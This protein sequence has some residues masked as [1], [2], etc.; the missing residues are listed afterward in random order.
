VVEGGDGNEA[1][2]GDGAIINSDFLN[3]L[4][5]EKAREEAIRR[6]EKA[7]TGKAQV[8]YRLRDW[9]V[10]RQRYWGCPI[11][12][13]HC[14]KCGAVPVPEKDLPVTL[15]EDVRFDK[16]GNPLDHHPTWKNVSCPN[17]GA[18]ARR[19]TDTFDTFFESSWYF[20]R[21]CSPHSKAPFDPA[22]AAYWMPVDCYIGGIEHAVL[23]LLYSR[24][25]MRALQ[26]CG[27]GVPKE[28]FTMLQ[29]Q[30][31]V[32]HET[33][34]NVQSGAWLSPDEVEKQPD[35]TFKHL[36]SGAKIEVGRL[37]KMSKSKKNTV[38][39]QRIID[40]YGADAARLFMLSDSPPERDLEW[41]D[42]GI[43]GSWRYLNRLWK[44]CL[45]HSTQFTALSALDAP[46][47]VKLFETYRLMHK[48]IASV[49]ADIEAFHFN[50]AVA[51]IREFTNALE[52]IEPGSPE[53]LWVLRE[54]VH[55]VLHLLQPFLPH[56][57][58]EA[59][60][61]LGQDTPLSGRP[62]PKAE[63]ALLADDEVTIAVQLNGKLRTTLQMPRDC[64]RARMEQ[65]VL[66]L[67]VIKDHL[68]DKR[69]EKVIVVPNRIVNVVAK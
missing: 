27:H 59:W 23:H 30:G 52:K 18:A 54:G 3:G 16:P 58:E 66:D 14:A 29:T 48:T 60:A 64:E 68:R 63:P 26:H 47:D 34:K 51:R 62:W 12:I 10:S 7:G 15:P 44:L 46:K 42:A 55:A 39:P 1:Y 41:S 9:G 67:A 65:T 19:E 11:P 22:A 61:Q 13:I 17:C 31:M 25:F 4:S 32:Y 21:F 49:T 40:T 43:E 20:A 6:F 56:I 8:N 45:Q 38:D 36:K 35:G 69:L 53:A 28:P 37:E 24:F 5:V 50:K 33:Y 57:A 2:T